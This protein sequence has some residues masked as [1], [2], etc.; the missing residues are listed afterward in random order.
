MTNAMFWI[1][2]FFHIITIILTI[3]FLVLTY[4]FFNAIASECTRCTSCLFAFSLQSKKPAR[5][6]A[7]TQYDTINDTHFAFFTRVAFATHATCLVAAVKHALTVLAATELAA[8]RWRRARDVARFAEI[9]LFA[10]ANAFLI[11]QTVARA[12]RNAVFIV[13]LLATIQ[14]QIC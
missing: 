14:M 2:L 7:R 12:R 11:T 5:E 6:K 8:R 4:F 1:S 10:L 13:S 9:V 3:V